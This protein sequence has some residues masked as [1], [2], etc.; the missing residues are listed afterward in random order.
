MNRTPSLLVR[1]RTRVS[2]PPNCQ[3]TVAV[4]G[5]CDSSATESVNGD[6]GEDDAKGASDD[7]IAEIGERM[8]NLLII[9]GKTADDGESSDDCTLAVGGTEAG[10]KLNV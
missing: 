10:V 9:G 2:L 4:S 7:V 5:G 3:A 6:H 1:P 8:T